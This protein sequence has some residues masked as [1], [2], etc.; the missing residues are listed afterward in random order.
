MNKSLA[1]IY[2]LLISIQ[3]HSFVIWPNAS[4]PCNSTLQACVDGSPVGEY[5][6]LR[7]N[8]VIN[9]T[10]F[11]GKAISLVAGAGYKPKFAAGRDVNV[12]SNSPDT[13]TVKGLTLLD[14]VLTLSTIGQAMTGNILNNYVT[15]LNS[16]SFPIKVSI[17][18]SASK[19]INIKYNT[20]FHEFN[21]AP[22]DVVGAIVLDKHLGTGVVDGDIYGNTVTANGDYSRG[23]VLK[24]TSEGEVNMNVSANEV[25]GGTQAGIY[26]Y[27][28][29]TSASIDVNISSNALYK[30]N[31]I[32]E[33]SGIS[34]DG[35]QGYINA[36]IINNTM[37]NSRYGVEILE[38]TALGGE[39]DALVQ[40]NLVAYSGYGF[41]FDADAT[42]SNDYNLYYEN[43]FNLNF[44]PGPNAI[45]ANPLLVSQSNARLRK[46]SPA[47]DSGNSIILLAL[48][49]T[50]LI[51]A[52]GTNRLK[53]DVTPSVVVDRGAYEVGDRYFLHRH[54]GSGTYI[55]TLDNEHTNNQIN[56]D[57]IHIT[58]NTTPN[59]ILSPRNNDN[60]AIY[61]SSGKWQIF[62]Q[63][64]LVDIA[65]NAAF[66]VVKYGS[67]SNTFEHDA[68]GGSSL[69]TIDMPGLNGNINKILMVTQHWIGTYNPHPQGV[70]YGLGNW[71]IL[72]LDAAEIPAGSQFNVYYQ[73]PSKSAWEHIAKAANISVDGTYL[74]HPLINDVPCAEIQVT[75][76]ASQGVSNARPV[77]VAFDTRPAYRKW[78]I[79]N[80][81]ASPMQENAAFHVM[82]N[83]AQIAECTDLIFKHGFE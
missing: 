33:P 70:V 50:P 27:A 59:G 55:S 73:D 60:E 67:V 49:N 10:I 80:Q 57:D 8:A 54:S 52:D 61:Y 26:V 64:T 71:N 51:D 20:V 39:V 17:G 2:M 75:Q 79:I 9:E 12:Q 31:E 40:N 25:Y 45:N 44:T 24:N 34:I 53:R 47:I 56:A 42:I 46:N 35:I 18:T 21:T 7:T 74:D 76:S 63:S 15:S 37:I 81:D 11:T 3:V 58:A 16:S 69:T 41:Y 22:A 43:I 6:E 1:V 62:N 13:V 23:I 68:M 28:F 72:N 38:S 19:T 78:G 30:A 77:A 29:N 48:G 5:I 65:N 14:G 83:P 82:I 36:D 32:W 4:A 66:N